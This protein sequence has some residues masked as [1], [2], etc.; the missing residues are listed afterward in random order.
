MLI[1]SLLSLFH[2]T[3]LFPGIDRPDS[4]LPLRDEILR[5]LIE[6]CRHNLQSLHCIKISPDRNKEIDKK[7]GPEVAWLGDLKKHHCRE[8]FDDQVTRLYGCTHDQIIY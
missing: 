6:K 4:R 8:P 3:K 2:A 1:L 5:V 7:A